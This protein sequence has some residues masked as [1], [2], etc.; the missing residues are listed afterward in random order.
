MCVYGN[1][2]FP[3]DRQNIGNM[4]KKKKKGERALSQ[5]INSSY[6]VGGIPEAE[7][8]TPPCIL[9]RAELIPPAEQT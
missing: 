8:E 7:G 5:S 3:E 2:G 6:Y 4:Y 9:R 1:T